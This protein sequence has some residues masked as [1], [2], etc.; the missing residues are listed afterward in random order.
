M[1]YILH[2]DYFLVDE[3]KESCSLNN[4]RFVE[5]TLKKPTNPFLRLLKKIHLN[6]DLPL[7]YIWV[8]QP[9]GFQYQSIHED[10]IVI[11]MDL[12]YSA[13]L[14]LQLKY[15]KNTKTIF[16]IW[17]KLTHSKAVQINLV[18]K[19]NRNVWTFD[20]QDSQKYH[21]HFI[22]QFYWRKH[23]KEAKGNIKTDLYFIGKDKKRMSTLYLI[24]QL[25][26]GFHNSIQV[27]KDSNQ[28][29]DSKY[30]KYLLDTDV[31]YN[32]VVER[33][34]RSRCLLEITIDGQ[35]GLTLRALEAL[36]YQKKLITNNSTIVNYDF[37]R[38]ANILILD[39][40]MPLTEIAAQI[41][42]FMKIE[43]VPIDDRII[44]NYTFENWLKKITI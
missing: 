37:Y 11:F 39:F 31:K 9:K 14:T 41:V 3:I 20:S 43:Y 34:L 4:V 24:D 23:I 16:Y 18:K 26:P 44:Q 22:E 33:I 32:K 36:F 21:L 30:T 38:E 5:M 25:T 7:K 40:K 15:F 35:E 42:E 29:Y 2:R 13:Y 28:S 8:N 17:N 1:I 6:L 27:L 12:P 19:R 10:D